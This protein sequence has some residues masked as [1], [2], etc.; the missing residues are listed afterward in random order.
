MCGFIGEFGNSQSPKN[1]FNSLLKLSSNRGPDMVGYYNNY[2]IKK[3]EGPFIQFGFNRLSI[4]DLSENA[5]QPIISK[6]KRYVV[7]FNG[8]ITNYLKLKREM[9]L[10]SKDLRTNSD[11]EVLCHA[12]D[13]FGIRDAINRINGMYAIVIYDLIKHIIYLIRDPAGIKPLYFAKTKFGWIFA[14]QYNQI[15]K[16]FWFKSDLQINKESLSDYLRLGYIPAPSALFK[17]SWMLQP[18]TCLTINSE[19]NAHLQQYHTLIDKC[20]YNET[21]NATTEKLS[22]ILNNT[23]ID[24]VHSDVPIGS[25]LSGGVDS[26]VVNAV[27]RKL[28]HKMNAFTISTKYL[29][30][31]ESKN[32]KMISKY[33][34]IEHDTKTLH[35]E[36][37]PSI[38]DNHFS[39][40]SEPFSDYS[41]IP[42][43]L[44]CKEASKYYKVL[45]SGDGGD[46]LFWGYTR[47]ASVMDYEKWFKYP[48][49]LRL[50]WAGILRRLGNKVSSCIEFDSIEDWVFER[51][52]P[53]WGSKIKELMP[54]ASHSFYTKKL[55]TIP[56]SVKT[57]KDLLIWLR[58]NEF[59]GHL[60]RVL[61]KVDR[62]S[63]A[64]GIEVR[65]PFLDRRVIDFCS[66]ISPE[67]GI[68][69]NDTK[70]LLKKIFKIY[71]PENYRLK[72][73]QGF[74]FDLKRLL[75]NELKEDFS[76][77]LMSKNL[78]GNEV[79]DSNIVHKMVVDFY[80]EKGAMN[81]WGLWTLYSLQKWA[82]L[83]YNY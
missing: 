78:F 73:K 1:E 69:H 41:S 70:Y 51:Q 80:K 40:F 22:N 52:S 79:I 38:I 77:T 74:S 82:K 15:F 56:S 17:K 65:V 67:L 27:L 61:L 6:S 23:F 36:E 66:L 21:D 34:G 12:F 76:D 4:L 71:L 55:Y 24:Y 35:W 10:K 20:E 2:D 59:Y 33:L 58:K 8:E 62:A 14:S 46:E 19:L 60:Q 43:Y 28:G 64:H 37:I 16:H 48:K 7:M 50:I 44:I 11:T 3:D 57:S 42:T 26:P 25:F 18:G 54:E 75:K 5:N 83:V 29:G 32:A 30:I 49:S 68:S 9:G 47:F 45:L 53:I 13:H 63:M 31:D 39:A 72:Y 81:E